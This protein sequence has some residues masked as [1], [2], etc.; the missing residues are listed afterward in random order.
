M[1]GTNGVQGHL[2]AEH[3]KATCVHCNFHI[4]NLCIAEVCNLPQIR[5]MNSTG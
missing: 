3:F 2:A 4:L 5:N 1:S